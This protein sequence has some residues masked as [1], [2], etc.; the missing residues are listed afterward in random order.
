MARLLAID[1]DN[2]KL[3]LAALSTTR[4]GVALEQAIAWPMGE[5]LTATSG[6]ALGHK[7]R[8]AL[9]AAGIASA[10]I[11][12]CVGRERV[13]VKELRYPP[14]PAAEEPALVRFQAA[15]ELSELPDDVVIDYAPLTPPGE[16]GE[17]RALA[18]A[19]RKNAAQAW[20]ALSR[21]LGVKLLALTTRAQALAGAVA[22][23][24]AEG[25]AP[26]GET[27]A[28]IALG[29]L[30]AELAVL[31]QGRM[32]FARSLAVSN[33][34]AADVKRSLSL[35]ASS[36]SAAT[37]VV[38][39]VTGKPDADLDQRLGAACGLPVQ[40]L[41]ALLKQETTGDADQNML[42]VPVGA[43]HVWARTA[44]LPI[45]FIAPKQSKI[46][47]ESTRRL[48]LIGAVAAAVFVVAAFIVGN[49]VL[50]DRK[51][52]IGDLNQRKTDAET[53]FRNMAQERLDVQ[54]LKEWEDNTVSWVDEI[55]DLAARLPHQIGFRLKDFTAG[56]ILKKSGKDAGVATVTFRGIAKTTH[57]KEI[58]QLVESLNADRHLRAMLVQSKDVGGGNQEFQIKVDIAR[59]PANK[60]TTVLHVPP[61]P[62]VQADADNETGDDPPD[63]PPGEMPAENEKGGTP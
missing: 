6:E 20:Q 31:H 53:A 43:A 57:D 23:A 10:P 63:P 42:A 18:V 46:A 25:Q 30:S 1:W 58:A 33:G 40:R 35:F 32:M 24:Q 12:A 26:A 17:R 21:G 28:V 7:L 3:Q 16:P 48:K 49:R 47:G 51:T 22:R 59:L 13:V 41:Q 54:A 14:V 15:K 45:N 19:L 8:D 27:L 36:A 62:R 61:R 4:K 60:Y 37:P 29:E 2:N 39:L 50:A 56:P 9:R 11:V 52:Q 5:E 55:Y 38:L 44:S 34:L